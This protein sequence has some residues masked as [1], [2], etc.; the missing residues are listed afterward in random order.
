M[1][2]GGSPWSLTR[3][4]MGKAGIGYLYS[5]RAPG[6]AAGMAMQFINKEMLH[7]L[8]GPRQGIEAASTKAA[9][10]LRAAAG[11]TLGSYL[12]PAAAQPADWTALKA[13]LPP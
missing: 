4:A 3:S 11:A 12:P 1:G 2:C 8:S 13:R 7:G 9:G 6:L 10:G 5:I